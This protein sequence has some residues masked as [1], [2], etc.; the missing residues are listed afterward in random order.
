[1]SDKPLGTL[2][3]DMSKRAQDARG[4]LGQL[5]TLFA[6]GDNNGVQA[7]LSNLTD[8]KGDGQTS[9]SGD[10]ATLTDEL[11]QQVVYSW[12]ERLTANEAVRNQIRSLQSKSSQYVQ[13]S[14][15]LITGQTINRFLNDAHHILQNCP[16]SV[17]TPH[18]HKIVNAMLQAIEGQIDDL[19][20]RMN[21]NR[22]RRGKEQELKDVMENL[23]RL[24]K[25]IR[26]EAE[27]KHRQHQQIFGL[28]SQIRS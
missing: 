19:T 10:S 25:R 3:N 15:L 16:D 13:S 26:A 8:R 2:L 6:N 23:N 22:P 1:M 24:L 14:D 4:Q 20:S 27:N 28:Q 11:L 17:Y 12:R 5:Y 7:A 9:P 18:L 21:E